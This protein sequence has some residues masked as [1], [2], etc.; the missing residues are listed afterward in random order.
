MGM[1]VFNGLQMEAEGFET[2]ELRAILSF[3][4]QPTFGKQVREK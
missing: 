3:N 4:K 2:R 1:H